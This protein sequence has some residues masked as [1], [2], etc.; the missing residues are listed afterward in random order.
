MDDIALLL[1]DT[2]DSPAGSDPAAA[3]P[4]P[5]PYRFPPTTQADRGDLDDAELTAWLDLAG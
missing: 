4:T 5:E 2:N 3:E 1:T